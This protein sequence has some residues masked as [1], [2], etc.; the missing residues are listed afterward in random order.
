MNFLIY[1]LQSATC[2]TILWL[3]YYALV[4]KETCYVFNRFFLL[5]IIPVCIITPLLH[6]PLWITPK[7]LPA[8]NVSEVEVSTQ[9]PVVENM[10][11]VFV[12]PV[13]PSNHFSI[14]SLLL[15]VYCLGVIYFS[16]RFA[17]Q[18]YKLYRFSVGN[19]SE[20]SKY[21]DAFTFFKKIYI[22]RKAFSVEDYDKILQHEQ[23]HAR[24]LH[25][26]DLMLAELFIVFQFFNPF[27][28]LL[29]KSLSEVHEYY[30]DA[31]VL[32]IFPE[33]DK[34][35]QLLY[36]QAVGLYPEY[37][38]GF[39][40][41]LTKKRL[42]MMTKTKRSHWLL[43]KLLC[44]LLITSSAVA[45]FSCT[46]Q[47]QQTEN[48]ENSQQMP[49]FIGEDGDIMEYLGYNLKYPE[50]AIKAGVN[51]RVIY[52]FVVEEDGSISN[53]KWICTHIEKDSNNPDVITSQ[54]ACEKVAFEIIESTSKLWKPAKKDNLPV[55]AEMSLPIW[56]KFH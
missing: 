16:F 27:A 54:K 44:L 48:V 11:T 50:E 19:P 47:K 51:I 32:A 3:A 43:V 13:L 41:S 39:N 24:Q 31:Q 7:I 8:W 15:P 45:F 10:M 33:A 30:A 18:L 5:S 29:K 9:F 53:I 17:R 23:S 56:F 46:K 28:W 20:N 38:S 6:F 26:L 35:K 55:K 1:I 52:S 14:F 36:N 21:C 12:E 2:A 37:A 34:Y 25:S 40:Y 42:K 22:N 4:R 49:E